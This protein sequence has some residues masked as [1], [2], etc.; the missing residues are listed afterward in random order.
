MAKVVRDWSYD[1]RVILKG[2]ED[3][4]VLSS[5]NAESFY[6]QLQSGE[7]TITLTELDEGTGTERTQVFFREAIKFV[8]TS[9]TPKEV[10]VEDDNCK[11]KK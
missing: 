9:R 8:W 3:P 11:P 4:V 6:H 10:Q 7:K 5:E 1:V 2:E